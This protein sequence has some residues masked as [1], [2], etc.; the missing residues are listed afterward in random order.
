MVK[1]TVPGPLLLLQVCVI[2]VAPEGSPSSLTVPSRLAVA[3]NCMFWFVPASTVGAWF[4]GFVS[5]VMF[6]VAFTAVGSSL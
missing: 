6:T 5:F 3:G 2:A 1:V 4:V